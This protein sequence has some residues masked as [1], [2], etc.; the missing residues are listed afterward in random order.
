LKEKLIVNGKGDEVSV[1]PAEG[2][3]FTDK[4]LSYL[5]PERTLEHLNESIRLSNER[6]VTQKKAEVVLAPSVP[7]LPA[8]ITVIN[9]EHKGS[10]GVDYRALN[11]VRCLIRETPNF[12]EI[13]AGDFTDNFVV[14]HRSAMS[15]SIHEDIISPQAQAQL[16]REI[17]KQMDKQ[18]KLIAVLEG[19][20][21]KFTQS[22]G[23]DF[24]NTW[25]QDLNC[26]VLKTGGIVTVKFG[27]QEY[28][29][30]L[31]HKYRGLGG[32]NPSNA[33]LKVIAD[34]PEVDV[35][36]LGHIHR[37]F[38][39]QFNKGGKS[40]LG[41]IGGTFKLEDEHSE[42]M[43]YGY[44]KENLGGVTF[45]LYPDVKRIQYFWTAQ[46][47]AEVAETML[48]AKKNRRGKK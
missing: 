37:R 5:D 48:D 24:A 12:Y 8:F 44:D 40:R 14:T 32:E 34:H 11:A 6:E 31:G 7:D 42:D 43:G 26:P 2:T 45:V 30:F 3:R 28:K 27:K 10:S 17:F 29:I 4:K 36:V 46:E 9:D 47:A 18:K 35:I 33:F 23:Y 16:S 25:L 22:V 1:L 19:N 41:I 39:S 13:N 38:V 20:H 15:G 21:D